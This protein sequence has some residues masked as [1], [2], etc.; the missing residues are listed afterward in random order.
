MPR[1]I[2]DISSLLGIASALETEKFVS[3]PSVLPDNTTEFSTNSTNLVIL[4]VMIPFFISNVPVSGTASSLT[5]T[6]ILIP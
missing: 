5:F 2:L 4:S 6:V 1:F 3:T